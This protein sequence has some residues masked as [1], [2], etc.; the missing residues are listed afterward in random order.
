MRCRR[1]HLAVCTIA[2]AL[3]LTAHAEAPGSA[4]AEARA[5]AGKRHYR[6][7]CLGCHGFSGRGDGPTAKALGL[8]TPNFK[9]PQFRWDT[10]D[11]GQAGTDADLRN[12][13]T[14]G[15]RAYE[16]ACATTPDAEPTIC[17]MQPW[18]DTLT[19]EQIELLIAYIRSLAPD[20]AAPR[21]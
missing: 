13:I 20:P 6:V 14:N 9:K 18:G 1:H 15:V 4:D 7:Y 12:V 5:A 19:D 17:Q 11:D 3:G 2:L 16:P 10:D 8:P 21:R